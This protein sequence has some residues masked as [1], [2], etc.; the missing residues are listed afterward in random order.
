MGSFK[1]SETGKET[2]QLR[3]LFNKQVPAKVSPMHDWSFD[4]VTSGYAMV[5]DGQSLNLRFRTYTQDR[6]QDPH[7]DISQWS[8]RMLLRLWDFNANRLKID[9]NFLN[10][11]PKVVDVYLCQDGDAGGEQRLDHD[12]KGSDNR[13]NTIYIYQIKKFPSEFEMARELAHEYGHATLPQIRGYDAP[14]DYANGQLGE[15]LYL[16]WLNDAFV[17]DKLNEDDAVGARRPDVTN[18]IKTKVTPLVQRIAA[19][20]PDTALLKK[21]SE[22]AFY[23]Y[24]ALVMYAEAVTPPLCLE[25]S[26]KSNL[27]AHGDAYE[28]QLTQAASEVSAWTVK[29][30]PGFSD[31]PFYIPLG[32]GTVTGAKLLSRKGK[33]AKVQRMGQKITVKNPPVQ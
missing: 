33:W 3:L 7:W 8:T 25:R 2:L 10:S 5:R 31:K 6:K 29:I 22:S 17:G 15:R 21:S 32:S 11:A 20:G 28:T 1:S 13:V 14:E 16:K 18:Y 9:H 4:Y 24:V 23:E 12:P 27:G 19:N 30:P 26:L